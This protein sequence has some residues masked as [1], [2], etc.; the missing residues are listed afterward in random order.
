[1]RNKHTKVQ[2]SSDVA[3]FKNTRFFLKKLFV[4]SLACLWCRKRPGRL[5]LGL[6]LGFATEAQ[7]VAS[8]DCPHV[9]QPPPLHTHTHQE[10]AKRKG[11]SGNRRQCRVRAPRPGPRE[12]S[13]TPSCTG[14]GSGSAPLQVR[15]SRIPD[16]PTGDLAVATLKDLQPRTEVQAAAAEE[17]PRPLPAMPAEAPQS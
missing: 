13:E 4:L 6:P 3:I 12:Q 11:N 2:Q 15:E 16:R 10:P 17:G 9:Q 1:M 5:P 8:R 14:A 7:Q